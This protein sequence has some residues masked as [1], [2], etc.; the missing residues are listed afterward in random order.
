M[1]HAL[2]GKAGMQPSNEIPEDVKAELDLEARRG[3]VALAS[4]APEQLPEDVRSELDRDARLAEEEKA[5]GT[6]TPDG[7]VLDEAESARA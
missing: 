4:P 3:S 2:C 5:A 1:W 7:P 6:L